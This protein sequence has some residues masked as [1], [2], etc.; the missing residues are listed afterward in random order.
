MT[1]PETDPWPKKNRSASI[2][3]LVCV[4]DPDAVGLGSNGATAVSAIL[5]RSVWAMFVLPQ[6]APVAVAWTNRVALTRVTGSAA[7]GTTAV[8]RKMTGKNLERIA[9]QASS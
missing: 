5:S 2:I 7:A 3:L 1:W 8:I 6:Q 9:M 4:A